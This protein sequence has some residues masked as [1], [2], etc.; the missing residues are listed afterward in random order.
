MRHLA[1]AALAGLLATPAAAHHG[2][3]GYDAA[4]PVTLDGTIE[5]IEPAGPHVTIMI[6]SGAKTLEIVLAPPSRMNNRGLPPSDLKVGETVRVLGYRHRARDDEVR[7]E[8]IVTPDMRQA[9]QLR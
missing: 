3:G 4:N 5:R 1:L 2:W 8:W 9:V 6:R 7:A